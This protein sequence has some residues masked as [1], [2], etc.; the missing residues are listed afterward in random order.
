MLRRH[1][2]RWLP[3]LTC[4][5]YVVRTCAICTIPY[6]LRPHG[7]GAA[8]VLFTPLVLLYRCYNKIYFFKFSKKR[9]LL[10][11]YFGR[12]GSFIEINFDQF[13]YFPRVGE[14]LI[15]IEQLTVNICG[16]RLF[17]FCLTLYTYLY[18]DL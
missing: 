2:S 13:F 5:F 4:V 14:K 9:D 15:V 17:T 16:A 3:A 18:F 11:L 1:F 10:D 12:D 8:W 6:N 7:A